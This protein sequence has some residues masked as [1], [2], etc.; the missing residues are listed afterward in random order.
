MRSAFE[1]GVS[2]NPA[3]RPKGIYGGRIRALITLDRIMARDDLQADLE[4]AVDRLQDYVQELGAL[5]CELKDYEMG[6]I[7]F[8]GRHEGHAVCLCWKLGEEKIG[9]WHEIEAG[10]AGRQPVSKLVE[11]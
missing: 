11:S 10:L 2:G 5:G 6:L 7:D 8:P 4:A 9:F 3:G 1:P